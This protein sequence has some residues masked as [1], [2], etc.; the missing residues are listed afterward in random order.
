MRVDEDGALGNSTYVN[1]LLVDEFNI[2][3]ETTC[4]D[5]SWI[6]GKNEIHNIS[7]HNMVRAGLL[8][9]NQHANKWCCEAETSA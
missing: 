3:I 5:S 4:G 2:S 7:I 9:S 8:D 1:N 6:N